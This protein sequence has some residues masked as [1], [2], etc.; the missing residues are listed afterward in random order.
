MTDLVRL[1]VFGPSVLVGVAAATG[2]LDRAGL[3]V[4]EV[5]AVSSAQQFEALLAGELDAVLTS[6]DNVLAHRDADVRILAA[7]DRG[8]GLSLFCAPGADPAKL[9]G[10]V[11]AVDVPRSG[12]AFVAY[13]LLAR[14]GLHAG[15]D[16]AVLALGT[17]P[18]RAA[19]LAAGECT[20]S[21]LNAGNDLRA[22]GAGCTRISRA[23]TLGPYVGAVLAAPGATVDG[24]SAAL[25]ALTTALLETSR[26]LVAGRL[27][28]AA[29]A[30]TADRLGLDDGGVRRYL[31]MLV[32]PREGLVGDGRL[33][34][35]ALHTL[36]WLR[37]AHGAPPPRWTRA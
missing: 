10:G 33:D 2:A 6:P 8:L 29:A 7:I 1:G 9:R 23:S 16:Y 13:A 31:R 14:L 22:E 36:C 19:A 3:T 11:L 25:W 5:P 15:L 32:D 27:H 24:G 17:T 12:F 37:T 21:V 18:R 26:A 35:R 30:V 34:Q 28:P 4:E 20:M